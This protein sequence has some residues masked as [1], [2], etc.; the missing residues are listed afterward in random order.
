MPAAEDPE[1]FNRDT[2]TGT[3][4]DAKY[5]RPGFEDKSFGQAVSQ[6]QK[7]ADELMDETD[8][9]EAEAERRFEK[10]ATGAPAIA[11]Q[12]GEKPGGDVEDD[13]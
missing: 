4:P 7:L 9:N 10:S 11:R 2:P 3:D 1:Q 12:H 8:G 13:A 6:D 5:E